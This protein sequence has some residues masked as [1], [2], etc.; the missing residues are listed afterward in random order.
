MEWLD[1]RT[2]GSRC[3]GDYIS[4]RSGER[5]IFRAVQ[6]LV[7]FR[8][9]GATNWQAFVTKGDDGLSKA[10]KE[11]EVDSDVEAASGRER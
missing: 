2:E 9:V 4:Y 11:P 8:A 3:E 7:T 6:G 10:R 1:G 5:S